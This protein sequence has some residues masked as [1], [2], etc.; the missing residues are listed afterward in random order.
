M[1]IYLNRQRAKQS[2]IL[3]PEQGE[4]YCKSFV[5]LTHSVDVPDP[6]ENWMSIP[7]PKRI[8]LDKVAN[9]VVCMIGFTDLQNQCS[10]ITSKENSSYLS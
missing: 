10:D 9:H 2:A 5:I 1:F 8:T 7:G 4:C 3:N 6:F